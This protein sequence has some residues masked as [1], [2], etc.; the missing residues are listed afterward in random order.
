MSVWPFAEPVTIHRRVRAGED[1]D[2]NDAWS[3]TNIVTRAALYPLE[4]VENT[5][6]QDTSIQRINVVF[7]PPV[8]LLVTDK[9]S[10]RG[11]LWDVDGESGDYQSPLTGTQIEKATLKR[12]T[13]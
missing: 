1:D 4:S 9:L 10:A 12:V 6:A 7:K 11:K 5:D 3:E 8:G 13:G 2:G